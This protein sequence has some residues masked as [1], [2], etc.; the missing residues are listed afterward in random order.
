M[1]TKEI[2]KEGSTQRYTEVHKPASLL[3]LHY[4]QELIYKFF[5]TIKYH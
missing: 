2:R 4:F 1:K 3:L 5:D